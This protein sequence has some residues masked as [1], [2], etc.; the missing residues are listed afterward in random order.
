MWLILWCWKGERQFSTIWAAHTSRCLYLR[1]SHASVSGLILWSLWWNSPF[2]YLELWFYSNLFNVLICLCVGQWGYFCRK[3]L[4]V[5]WFLFLEVF[6]FCWC[7]WHA[8][9]AL[10]V[11][12]G[13][14]VSS[15]S[16]ESLSF[17]RMLSKFI[18]S[19][20]MGTIVIKVVKMCKPHIWKDQNKY[21]IN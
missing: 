9:F 4:C 19:L 17:I 5:Q 8:V 1:S 20:I 11:I 14:T 18:S 16:V 10:D 13:A 3:D 12:N 21:P 7:K 6:H 2:L 15:L